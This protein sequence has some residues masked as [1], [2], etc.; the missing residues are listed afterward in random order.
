[1]Y[2][3]SNSTVYERAVSANAGL[4]APPAQ[5]QATGLANNGSEGQRKDHYTHSTPT[6]SQ[7][8]RGAAQSTSTDYQAEPAAYTA[9]A[10][11]SHRQLSDTAPLPQAV[12]ANL[13]HQ[14]PI[15]AMNAKII[16]ITTSSS[17]SREAYSAE[18]QHSDS[19]SSHRIR[20]VL[21]PRSSAASSPVSVDGPQFNRRTQIPKLAARDDRRAYNAIPV[22]TNDSRR[23]FLDEEATNNAIARAF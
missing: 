7:S 14:V 2:S 19:G 15:G 8:L 6:S 22:D 3:D 4:I 9:S 13:G 10:T 20:P 12:K 1:M 16:N 11:V 23:Y 5:P 18:E 21:S 17:A